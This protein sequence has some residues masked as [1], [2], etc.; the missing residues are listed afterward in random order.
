MGVPD[1]GGPVEQVIRGG[2]GSALLGQG[3]G[4]RR[5][6]V[7]D[8]AVLTVSSE[9][10]ILGIIDTEIAAAADSAAAAVD[11]TA[12]DDDASNVP[13]CDAASELLLSVM[14]ADSD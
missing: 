11:A 13:A 1:L 7:G 5:E 12:D 6:Q 10:L 2:E 4:A 3:H 8:S 14:L 9:V